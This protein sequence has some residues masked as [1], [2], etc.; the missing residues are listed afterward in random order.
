MDMKAIFAVM[1]FINSQ[2]FT[3]LSCRLQHHCF[4]LLADL[5]TSYLKKLCFTWS[6]LSL[7]LI[8][9][10]KERN[11]GQC[12]V[13]STLTEPFLYPGVYSVTGYQWT[14]RNLVIS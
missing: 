9:K 4:H 8:G 5:L 11:L 2:P 1:T 7:C 12:V 10:T 3:Q 13:F 6:Y 14:V